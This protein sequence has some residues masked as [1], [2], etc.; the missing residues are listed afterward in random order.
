MYLLNDISI[1]DQQCT[2]KVNIV[3]RGTISEKQR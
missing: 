1:N 2:K 3:V